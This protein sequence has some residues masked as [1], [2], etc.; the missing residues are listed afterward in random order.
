VLPYTGRKYQTDELIPVFL[1]TETAIHEADVISGRRLTDHDV[2]RALQKLVLQVR[3]S[4]RPEP[5]EEAATAAGPGK[6]D[7]F[8]VWNI[9]GRWRWYFEDNPDPGRDNLV[10]V[11]R[12]TLKSIDVWGSPSPTSRGYL[13][14]I[15]GF[16]KKAGV[17][18]RQFSSEAEVMRALGREGELPAELLP[19]DDE[20]VPGG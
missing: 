2:R 5:A 16:L 10:G 3:S 17:S 15:E 7:D 8:V 9:L 4:G 12:T 19:L 14:E 6:L 13:R 20:E 11:L 18:V 1:E